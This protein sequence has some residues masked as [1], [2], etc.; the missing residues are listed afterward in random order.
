ME[1]NERSRPLKI[2]VVDDEQL[3]CHMLSLV[4]RRKG[5]EVAEADGFDAVRQQ[6]DGQSFDLVTCDYQMPGTDGIGVLKWLREHHPETGVVMAT[7]IDNLDVV[8]EAMRLGA[9]SYI[10]KPFNMD[11]VVEE[12]AR[13]LER[14]CLVA[15]NLAYQQRLEQMV[16]ERTEQLEEAHARLSCQVKELRGIDRL[17][18]L[19]MSPP[20]ELQEAYR[21]ILAIVAEVMDSARVALYRIDP[22]GKLVVAAAMGLENLDGLAQAG[23]DPFKDIAQSGQPW[24]GE[25]GELAVPIAYNEEVLGILLV[26]DALATPTGQSE[27]HNTLWRLGREIAMVFRIMQM[28]EDLEQGELEVDALLKMEA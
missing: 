22:A 15:E 20:V 10:L 1:I 3:V 5:Y 27:V 4:L 18:Q 24:Q 25:A 11:L 7:A 16:A 23:G 26:H 2:L 19:Q 8:I 12:V 28:A 17:T 9:Y 21:E 6:M 13:A 14:Q